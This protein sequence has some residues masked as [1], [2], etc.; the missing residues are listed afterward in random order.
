MAVRVR[1]GFGCAPS[2]CPPRCPGL[3]LE[4]RQNPDWE[5]LVTYVEPRGDAITE[6]LPAERLRPVRALM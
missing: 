3:V 6:W 5:A 2:T 4:W 1:H